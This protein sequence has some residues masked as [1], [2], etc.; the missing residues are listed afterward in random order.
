MAR[1]KA[2]AAGITG[3]GSRYSGFTVMARSTGPRTAAGK[4]RS[5]YNSLKHG[6]YARDVVLPGEDRAE[7]DKLLADLTAELDPHGSHETMLVGR[8]ADI[9]WQLGRTAAI[10]AGLLSPTW[11]YEGPPGLPPVR[12]GPL[13][14]TIRVAIDEVERLDQLGRYESRLARAFDTTAQ[15]LERRQAWRQR[16][17]TPTATPAPTST[18]GR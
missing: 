18:P 1:S 8:L 9:S 11:G 16:T 7:Y 17:A 13:V 4:A 6:L 3:N 15:L 10:E 5:A 2:I 14:D 12:G